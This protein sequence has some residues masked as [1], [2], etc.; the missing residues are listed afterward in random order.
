MLVHSV[1]SRSSTQAETTPPVPTTTAIAASSS[2]TRQSTVKSAPFWVFIKCSTTMSE[3]DIDTR[4]PWG[5]AHG[6]TVVPPRT[7]DDERSPGETGEPEPGR[8]SD[9][10]RGYH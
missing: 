4:G 10:G 8:T 2:S 6:K 3:H 1:I 7:R 5:K 9:A